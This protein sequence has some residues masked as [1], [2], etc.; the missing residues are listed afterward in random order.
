MAGTEREFIAKIRDLTQAAGGQ[1]VRGIGDDCAVIRGGAGKQWLITTD[2]LMES[3]HFD[4][5]WHP[6]DLLGR[7]TAA[8]NISDIAAMGGIPLFA[9]LALATPD[10]EAAWLPGFL[11]GFT[12]VLREHSVDLIGGDTVKSPGPAM[13][14]VTVIG[15]CKDDEIVYRAGALP[16]DLI[17]VSGPLGEAAAG[18][19]LCRRGFAKQPDLPAGW[20]RLVKAHL[21]PDPQVA[22]G[23]LLAA[24]HLSR[25]MMDLS[26]GL[27]TDLA[28]LCTESRVGAEINA[29]DLPLSGPLQEAAAAFGL[30]ALDWALKGGEDYQLLF[31][32]SAAHSDRV[33]RLAKELIGKE[34]YCIGRIVEGR[35]VYLCQGRDLK[36][37]IGF[38]GYDHFSGKQSKDT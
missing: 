34:I 18:L 14:S 21:D 23:R 30:S 13:F 26:D 11:A 2:T 6:S 15:E 4:L 29:G 31:V 12:A 17:W 24:R 27:A 7:K 8:V 33:R 35:G 9:L 19:E 25:A 20:Q 36:T 22:V 16:Q 32:T 38:Q 28:H 10:P 37:E 5:G 3:V 1:V